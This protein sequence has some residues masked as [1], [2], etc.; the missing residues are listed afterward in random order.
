M[1]TQRT[2]FRTGG[3]SDIE[4]LVRNAAES[5]K[6]DSYKG[7]RDEARVSNAL[8]LEFAV[9][10]DDACGVSAVTMQDIS[11]AGVAF[12]S[13]RCAACGRQSAPSSL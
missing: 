11:R 8:M 4:R 5:G 6:L 9:N 10:P 13:R 1:P 12:W 7:K 2:S 3:K